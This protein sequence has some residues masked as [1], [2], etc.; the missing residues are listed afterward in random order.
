MNPY[1]IPDHENKVTASPR[2]GAPVSKIHDSMKAEIAIQT[3][4]DEEE[5]AKV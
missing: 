2:K 3:Q 5:E 1:E 4:G